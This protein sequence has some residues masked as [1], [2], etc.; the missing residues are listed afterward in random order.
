MDK[1]ATVMHEM[2]HSKMKE[3]WFA[4][5][6][7]VPKWVQEYEEK[8]L[9]HYLDK[10]IKDKH[11]QYRDTQKDVSGE[12]LYTRFLDQHF[13]PDAAKKGELAG[14]DYKPYF[15]KILREE[16][17]PYAKAYK[18]ILKEEK[19]VKSK[20]YGLAG[21]GRPGTG[22]NYLLGEDDQN[23]RVPF[24]KGHSAGRRKFLKG[25]AALAAIPIVGKY[26]KWAKPLAK[27]AKVADLTSVPIKD[28]SGMPVWFKPLVN[29]VIK[30]GDDV[31]KTGF[32]SRKSQIVHKTKL[33]DSKT[34]MC[35]VTQDLTT[36]DVVVDIGMQVNMVLQMVI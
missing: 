12:E 5:S 17:A 4:K 16:W 19:R 11:S 33:P 35:M 25:I 13:Y 31:T 3:P 34:P 22:L 24:K 8:G 32:N 10:D 36:G 29:K 14:S 7:A 23:V 15:D 2:R 1:V 21:G 28:I 18:D 9:P 27:T 26:F 6:S 30:Q 20:P